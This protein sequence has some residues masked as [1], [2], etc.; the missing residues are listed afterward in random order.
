MQFDHL[1]VYY[2]RNSYRNCRQNVKLYTYIFAA[3]L[4]REAASKKANSN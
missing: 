3:T 4:I 1:E 2:F